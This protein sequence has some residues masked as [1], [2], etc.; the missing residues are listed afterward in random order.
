MTS[1]RGAKAMTGLMLCA[2]LALSACGQ[3]RPL[4]LPQKTPAA[5]TTPPATPA[6][7]AA[8]AVY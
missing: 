1:R 5:K 8:S 7:S 6:A 3:K 4:Q 2:V